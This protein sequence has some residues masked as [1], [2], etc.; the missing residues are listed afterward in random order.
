MSSATIYVLRSSRKLPDCNQIWIFSTGFHK[1]PQYQISLK[2]ARSVRTALIHADRLTDMT[3]LKGSFH[4]FA[5]APKTATLKKRSS[6]NT[7]VL[8][9]VSQNR[10]CLSRRKPAPAGPSCD[11]T[12]PQAHHIEGR[13]YQNV[14]VMSK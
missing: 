9:M 13:V 7:S 2:P 1:S 14:R 3:T 10:A 11:K 8:C 12:C 4:D 5:K 6:T